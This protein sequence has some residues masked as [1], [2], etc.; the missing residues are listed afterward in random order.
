[1]DDYETVRQKINDSVILKRNASNPN[2]N[3]Y[4]VS[5]VK[6]WETEG[7]A[8]KPRYIILTGA[9]QSISLCLAQPNEK[10]TR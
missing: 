7:N 10:L 3:E 9:P 5:H 8:E 4:Y 6:I 2:A 1:M